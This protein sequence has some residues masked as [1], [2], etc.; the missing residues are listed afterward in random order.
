MKTDKALDESQ[1]VNPVGA[2]INSYLKTIIPRRRYIDLYQLKD[3][4]HDNDSYGDP[5]IFD[6]HHLSP[7][8][9]TQVIKYLKQKNY[10]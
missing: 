2:R 10:F 9:A 5:Y 8:G 6:K 4:M 7:A 1:Y 3:L